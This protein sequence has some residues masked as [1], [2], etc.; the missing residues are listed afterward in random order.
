MR[1]LSYST[2]FSG[3]EISSK[4][5]IDRSGSGAR[6]ALQQWKA[7]VGSLSHEEARALAQRLLGKRPLPYWDMEK[8]R[9]REG[10]YR[11]LQTNSI[12]EFSYRTFLSVSVFVVV[13]TS[14]SVVAARSR[15]M[16]T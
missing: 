16:Q 11:Y 7:N 6:D 15:P 2:L 12:A 3:E 14:V 10:F 9:T 13:S 8:P 4:I 1:R 5:F